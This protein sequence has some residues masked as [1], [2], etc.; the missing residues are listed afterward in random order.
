MPFD[1]KMPDGTIIRGVPDGTTKTQLM[2]RYGKAQAGGIGA[3]VRGKP[4]AA[5]SIASRALNAIGMASPKAS[6]FGDSR[7]LGFLDE[8]GAVFDTLGIGG[9]GE[10]RPNVWKGDNPVDAW[11]YNAKRNA[12][13]L[14]ERQQSDP[15]GYFKGQITGAVLPGGVPKVLRATN[16]GQRIATGTRALAAAPKAKAAQTAARVALAAAPDVARGAV[17]GA[18]S[19]KGGIG[20]RLSAAPEGAAYGLAGHTAGKVVGKAVTSTLRGRNVSPAVRTLA[21]EGV[22]MTPGRRGGPVRRTYE[23]TVLGSI[24]FVK[25]IPQSANRRSIEQLN[26]AFYNR[27]LKPIGAKL[28]ISTKP[29]REAVEA[30]GN[31]VYDAYD[32]VTSKLSLGMDKPLITAIGSIAKNAKG[33]VG[34]NASQLKAIIDRT[35]A[36]LQSGSISG[37]RVR[38]MLQDLRREASQFARSPVANERRLGDELW[39]LHDQMDKALL[40]QNRGGAVQAFKAARESVSLLKRVEDAAAKAKDGIASPQQLRTAV[41]KR[42]YGTTTS[43]VA[44]GQARMQDLADAASQ[45]L[46]N[47]VP[48]S[49]SPERAIGA[50]IMAGGPASIMHFVDPTMGALA[51]SSLLGYAPGIDKLLQ[52]FAL[53]RPDL[54][55]RAGNA[56]ERASPALGTAGTMTALTQGR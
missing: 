39:R 53:K 9:S 55:I 15:S 10:Q 31:T 2:A 32:T 37:S 42:G 33:S 47:S 16:T 5:P 21:N 14:S 30:L 44:T 46:P 7:A 27:V 43:R 22:V 12:Q 49:G 18:G 17:Y 52:N 54:L 45:V 8:V 3:L 28:P 40:R 36:P 38:G 25:S 23:E 34:A 11:R 26:V 48:N 29:G 1:V 50:T 56:V 13:Q 19:A 51:G 35:I 4:A 41:T 20:E 6:G 24:P